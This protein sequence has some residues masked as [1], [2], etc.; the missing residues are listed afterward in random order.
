MFEDLKVGKLDYSAAMNVDYIKQLNALGPEYK[1]IRTPHWKLIRNL[2]F[3]EVVAVISV[4][5]GLC[6]STQAATIVKEMFSTLVS[7]FST[8]REAEIAIAIATLLSSPIP[9]SWTDKE[10][11]KLAACS[12]IHPTAD[13]ANRMSVAADLAD[14][15]TEGV[16]RKYTDR[17][18]MDDFASRSRY[19]S[20][21]FIDRVRQE[22][23]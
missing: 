3:D 22:Y 11:Y 14:N 12:E 9:Y 13:M 6:F 10:K 19:L 21:L 5:F 15:S 20:V 23:P 8:D 16:I 1:H 18:A 2:T 7:P 17:L 4:Q